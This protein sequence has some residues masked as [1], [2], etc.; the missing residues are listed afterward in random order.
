MTIRT[1]HYETAFES[2]LREERTPYI[3]V[4]ERRRSLY[5]GG[6][7]KSLDF[8]VSPSGSEMSWLVDVKGRRFPSGRNNRYWKNWTTTDELH[9]LTQWQRL[10]GPQF[11]GLLVF[12]YEVVG[13][14][15]PVPHY[16]LHQHQQRLYGFVG[17]RLDLYVAWAKQISPRWKT[18]AMPTTPFRQLAEPLQVTLRTEVVSGGD[19]DHRRMPTDVCLPG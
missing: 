13:N 12:A 10:L 19:F 18:V 2:F 6:S 5:G 9:S 1:N 4:D 17:I 16:F 14:V 15:S 7:L 3:A 11:R 8:I